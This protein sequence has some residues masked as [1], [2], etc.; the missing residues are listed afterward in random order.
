L[1][2]KK[3]FFQINEN[4]ATQKLTSHDDLCS[5]PKGYKLS[6]ELPSDLHRNTEISEGL[7]DEALQS[8]RKT[9]TKSVSCF[10]LLLH[11]VS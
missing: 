2:E 9:L 7:S 10:F 6:D 11:V 5:I 8:C 3:Y 1:S 4:S